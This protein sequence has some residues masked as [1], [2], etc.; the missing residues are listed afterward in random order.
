MH[1]SLSSDAVAGAI[2]ALQTAAELEFA[3]FVLRFAWFKEGG[4]SERRRRPR[5]GADVC[6]RARRV[7]YAVVSMS[8]TF[9]GQS[10]PGIASAGPPINSNAGEPVDESH[11]DSG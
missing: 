5:L 1:R 6:A 9:V 11:F 7:E 2:P 10:R 3:W 4:L 8:D